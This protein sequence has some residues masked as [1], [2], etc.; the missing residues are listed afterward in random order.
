MRYQK[1]LKY[2][3]AVLLFLAFIY[4]LPSNL[5]TGIIFGGGAIFL[6]V[7]IVYWVLN[8]VILGNWLDKKAY[9]IATTIRISIGVAFVGICVTIFGL[10]SHDLLAAQIGVAALLYGG[11]LFV[12]RKENSSVAASKH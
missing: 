5:L 9:E 6:P 3:L 8:E 1:R 2:Y 10:I 7:A 11:E 4:L 12:T